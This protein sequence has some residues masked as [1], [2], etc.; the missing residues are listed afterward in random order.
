MRALSI[1]PGNCPPDL[2]GSRHIVLLYVR[3][4]I[5]VLIRT[6]NLFHIIITLMMVNTFLNLQLL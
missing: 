4:R 2:V 6:L 5:S 3:I 1:D